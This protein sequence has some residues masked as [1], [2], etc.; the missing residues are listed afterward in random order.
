[1]ANKNAP[2]SPQKRQS[3]LERVEPKRA[4]LLI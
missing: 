4:T 2:S 1:M 3:V